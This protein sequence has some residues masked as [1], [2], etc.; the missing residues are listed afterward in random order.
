MKTKKAIRF[1]KAWLFT[2]I[3]AI[4]FPFIIKGRTICLKKREV[5]ANAV[6]D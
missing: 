1:F 6:K 3:L 5:K 2:I 4:L